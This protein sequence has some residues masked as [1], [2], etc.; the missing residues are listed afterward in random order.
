[1]YPTVL[2]L[3]TKAVGLAASA[4]S[5]PSGGLVSKGEMVQSDKPRVTAPDVQEADLSKLVAGNRGFALDLYQVLWSKERN[6]FYSPYSISVALAM[7]Y[8]GARTETERQMAEVLHFT[9]SQDR[10]HPALNALDVALAS[11]G[12]GAMGKD[13]KGFRLSIA[14]SIWGQV[15]YSFLREFLD[16]LAANYGAGL[17]VLDFRKAPDRCRLVINEWVSEQTEGK[18]RD[19]LPPGSILGAE[20]LVLTNA[21][22]FSAAWEFPFEQ[23]NTED[24]TFYLLDDGQVTVP[25][26][27]QTKQFRYVEGD[28]YQ[29]VE[30]PYDGDELS[31]VVLLPERGRFEEFAEELDASRVASILKGMRSAEVRLTMPK[32]TY[33]WGYRLGSTVSRLGMEA[34]FG[35]GADFSGM[36]GNRDLWIDDVIHKAFVA[37]DEA[38][39]EAAAATVT[40]LRALSAPGIPVEVTIDHPF[41]FVIRDIQTGAVLF[42]GH[43]VNPAE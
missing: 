26:M 34:A 22:Y 31:M 38:G 14:N 18:I 17:R 24:G 30:L 5:R 1:M 20:L 4:G 28:G 25:M 23:E 36:T 6:L 8:A 40:V 41:I 35:P 32:F 3:I 19:L 21:I 11:R 39:T 16:V 12:A 15:G 37:V 9:L 7:T 29:A 13:G 27:V 33:E 2:R 43:V 42:V 10:L